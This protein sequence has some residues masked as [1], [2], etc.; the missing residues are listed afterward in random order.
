MNRMSNTTMQV[1]LPMYDFPEIREVTEAWW[2]GIAK[3]MKLQGVTDVPGSL[4][5]E[6]SLDKLWKDKSLLI[7]QCCGF[8]VIKGYQD[9]LSVLMITDWEAEGC[10]PCKYS[11]HII[12]H[13]DSPYEKISQ[14]KD[15]TAVINGSDS[16]SG[17]AA[18][19]HV[20][21][22]YCIDGRFFKEIHIS[23]A[24]AESLTFVQS[25]Q[26]DI[27]AIDCVTFALLKRY[28]PTALD[29]IRII[30]QSKA[31]PALPYVTSVNTSLEI[32]QHMQFALKEAFADPELATLREA[33]LLKG[34]IF[35]DLNGTD[36]PYKE[37]ADGFKFDP[38]LLEP[39][40]VA[41]A[42]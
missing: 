20:V 1:S 38:K 12:V 11:S 24:H 36:N 37:I 23:G 9:Y 40:V 28:R 39:L 33:L 22:P 15:K 14:L 42:S 13:E 27:A 3:H 25:K 35:P 2:R 21:Q 26:A 5:H 17:M 16:H 32:Q 7:S 4:T 29:R 6:M 41:D 34:A 10:E 8:N 18:L 31:A 30:S 19:L